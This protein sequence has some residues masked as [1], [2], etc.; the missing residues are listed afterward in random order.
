MLVYIGDY[1]FTKY[2]IV[3]TGAYATKIDTQE[4]IEYKL[5]NGISLTLP[6]S[7]K[8]PD[9]LHLLFDECQGTEHMPD[10]AYF[11]GLLYSASHIFGDTLTVIIPPNINVD[12][13]IR[14]LR[15][16]FKKYIGEVPTIYQDSVQDMPVVRVENAVQTLEKMQFSNI[17]L[18]DI[19]L[20]FDQDTTY[21]FVYMLLARAQLLKTDAKLVFSSPKL[22]FEIAMLLAKLGMN[23]NYDY[24]SVHV[25]AKDYET[26]IEKPNTLILSTPATVKIVETR[27]VGMKPFVDM[28]GVVGINGVKASDLRESS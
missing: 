20:S 28:L 4:A 19:V 24:N 18:P 25:S 13:L 26:I 23:F 10:L 22:A 27:A 17:M 16:M 2:A 21:T 9:E 11:Y 8:V 1:T 6:A 7:V 12:E 3:R 14:F 15:H 5:S